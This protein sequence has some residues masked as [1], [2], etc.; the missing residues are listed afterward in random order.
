MS[1]MQD[2]HVQIDEQNDAIMRASLKSIHRDVTTLKSD[3]RTSISML[4]AICRKL[5]I[6]DDHTGEC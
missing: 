5:Q 1:E 2:E 3:M 4:Q 6:T